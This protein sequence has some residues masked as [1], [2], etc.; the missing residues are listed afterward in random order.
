V[1]ASVEVVDA[2]DLVEGLPVVLVV[3]V[4]ALAVGIGSLIN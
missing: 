3:N 1:E 4:Y 2:E